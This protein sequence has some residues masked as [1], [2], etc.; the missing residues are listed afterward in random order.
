[1][2]PF[3]LGIVKYR[4]VATPK[5]GGTRQPTRSLETVDSCPKGVR[6]GAPAENA[7]WHIFGHRTLLADRK[8]RLFPSVMYKINIFVWKLCRENVGGNSGDWEYLKENWERW[9]TGHLF[10]RPSSFWG[11]KSCV[12]IH[13]TSLCSILATALWTAVGAMSLKQRLHLK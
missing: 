1:M 3:R 9:G 7:Y 4:A 5:A 6:D 8:M 11:P 13:F 10:V 12:S 2:S